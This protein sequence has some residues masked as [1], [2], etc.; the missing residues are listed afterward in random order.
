MTDTEASTQALLAG[1]RQDIIERRI[2]SGLARLEAWAAPWGG[3]LPDSSEAAQLAWRAAQWVDVG[4]R[5]GSFV[6]S[7][8]QNISRE[9]RARL[10]LADY[11]AVRTAEGYVAMASEQIDA[12]IGH[13]EAVGVL[14]PDL[15][16]RELAAIA[17]FWK[18]RCHRQKGEY[19]R[20]M[21]LTERAR[22]LAAGCGYPRMAA[23]M[24]VLESWLYFQ[25]G[26]HK[27]S[28]RILGEVEA[29]LSGTDDAV[30]LGNIQS[31]YGRVFRQQGRQDLA[32]EHFT[33][34]IDHYRSMDPRHPHLA[35]TLANIAYVKRLVALDLRQR[36]DGEIAKRR[37]VARDRGLAAY[38]EQFERLS[39]E[40][41]AHLQ[42]A[43]DSYAVHPNRH[44]LGTVH[45]NRG[46]LHLDG[47]SLDVAEAE[48]ERAF[49]LGQGRGD[50]ILMARARILECMV[51]NAKLEEGIGDPRRHGQAALEH[52]REAMEL[53]HT[54]Q[55]R[56]VLARAHT[57]HGLTLSNEYFADL[58]GAREA[59]N[60]AAAYLDQGFHDTAW[61]DLRTLKGRVVKSHSVD[62]TLLAWSQGA[63]GNRT[64]RDIEEQFAEIVIPKVWEA[65]GRKIARVAARLSISPKKVRRILSRAGLLKARTE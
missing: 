18:A 11:A 47:G 50:A 61:A 20:A 48:A 16:D 5:D 38:H 7:I 55:N 31:T 39:A 54:T 56:R 26:K 34:A 30:V 41:F 57:W 44:G 25:K 62:E 46:L 13:F 65:E 60:T 36:I 33:R 49:L 29:A 27:E 28:L 53:A 24:R 59:M 45:M 17:G 14:E 9:T 43:A 58:D 19:E 6:Q 37:G 52:I 8:L 3:A 2:R 40:A 21:L 42:E 12:A 51:E 64:F 35:R 63:V 15:E 4:F 22:D 32:I 1:L 23:V 10:A